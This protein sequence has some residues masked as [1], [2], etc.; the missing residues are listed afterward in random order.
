MDGPCYSSG[1]PILLGDRICWAN[2]LGIV[3][4]VIETRSYSTAFPESD[5]SYLG[6]GFM[7]DVEG[8]GLVH[9]HEANGD[10]KLVARNG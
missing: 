2:K 10:L 3:V 9:E 8:V 5:W 6:R 4:F 1:D 7:L